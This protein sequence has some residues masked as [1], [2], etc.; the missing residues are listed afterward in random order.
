MKLTKLTSLFR[1]FGLVSAPRTLSAWATLDLQFARDKALD[2]RITFTR[3]SS[4]TYF[5][6]SGVLQTA[7]ANQARFDHDPETGESLGLLV[8]ESRTN[9]IAPSVPDDGTSW[10]VGSNVSATENDDVSPDGTSSATYY[11]ITAVP[12]Q[13]FVAYDVTVTASTAYTFSF[14]IKNDTAS[15]LEYSALDLIAAAD[16]VPATSY[17]SQVN[18]DSYTRISFSFTTPVGCT[19]ARVFISRP[20]GETGA[21]YAWGAQL[22][23]GSFP[24]S[25]IPTTD[26]T[27]T[28]EADVAVVDG[29]DFAEF[30]RQ[31]EGTIYSEF[32]SFRPADSTSLFLYNFSQASGDYIAVR[33]FSGYS[34]DRV[35][36]FVINGSVSQFSGDTTLPNGYVVMPIQT[37]KNALAYKANDF[38]SSWNGI[39]AYTDSSG[40]LPSPNKLFIGSNSTVNHLN[41]HIARLSYYNKRL[42]NQELEKLTS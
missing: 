36:P 3:A 2:P 22:E 41:G 38:A 25:Y 42:S 1:L 12:G 28:R 30:Y 10:N 18:T 20:F 11:E 34:P 8:E 9:L 14:Y 37:A 39:S 29:D 32:S 5:D 6:E 7:S 33:S 27:V 16:I 17:L 13:Q 15:D 31:D 19:S 24:T 4:G 40:S 35:Y 21:F 23:E 26:S